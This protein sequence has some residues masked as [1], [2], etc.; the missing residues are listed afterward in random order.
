M[1]IHSVNADDRTFS[2]RRR[3]L[4]QFKYV[5]SLEGNDVATG[6]KWSLAHNSVVV[7]EVVVWQ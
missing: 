4:M 5:L 2:A 6:L 3:E 7:I 1:C